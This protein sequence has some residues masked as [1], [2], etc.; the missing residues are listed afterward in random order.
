MR[1]R[2]TSGPTLGLR[3]HLRHDPFGAPWTVHLLGEAFV[4]HPEG[5]IVP[6]TERV[7]AAALLRGWVAQYCPITPKLAHE[8]S[9]AVFGRLMTLDRPRYL[10]GRVDQDI[11]TVFKA[12]HQAGWVLSD[13]L[14]WA[15]WQDT[16]WWGRLSL[17]STENFVTPD[18]VLFR[19]GWSQL[20]GS[21]QV[22]TMYRLAQFF[23]NR[24]R[25]NASTRHLVGLGVRHELWL[26]RWERVELTLDAE[27]DLTR[28][29]GAALLFLTW[30]YG[31]GPGYRDFRPDEVD[32]LELRRRFAAERPGPSIPSLPW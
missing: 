7:E 25:P 10:P 24:D 29:V 32:F 26:R 18:N 15:P 20:L 5:A 4:Q 19:V 31:H 13:T 21:C 23:A 2:D 3:H 30:H 8:P 12:D 14:A 1:V 11:F 22:D 16:R 27:Y 17:M 9:L 6:G 28:R